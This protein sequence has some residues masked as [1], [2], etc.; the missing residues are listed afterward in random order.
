MIFLLSVVPMQSDCLLT[1]TSEVDHSFTSHL[2]L[3]APPGQTDQMTQGLRPRRIL[4]VVL[5][6]SSFA[7]DVNFRN[8]GGKKWQ[9]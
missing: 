2:R 9:K 6:S 8:L 1:P 3:S 4:L 5:T 7:F